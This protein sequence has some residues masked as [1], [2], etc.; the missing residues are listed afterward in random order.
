MLKIRILHAYRNSYIMKTLDCDN[1]RELVLRISM[2]PKEYIHVDV[3]C[4]KSIQLQ[5]SPSLQTKIPLVNN[6]ETLSKK[7]AVQNIHHLMLAKIIPKVL[8]TLQLSQNMRLTNSRLFI[9]NQAVLLDTMVWLLFI[10]FLVKLMCIKLKMYDNLMCM[11][12][13]ISSLYD[14][15]YRKKEVVGGEYPV[16]GKSV[17]YEVSPQT[18]I[19]YIPTLPTSMCLCWLW[20]NCTSL[21]D[22]QN[23]QDRYYTHKSRL[24]LSIENVP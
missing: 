18:E 10:L 7:R 14:I 16:K 17:L 3:K 24:N 1:I 6:L 5:V 22:M 8:K 12:S 20:F 15:S 2:I 23:L 4:L 13:N 11:I 9:L 21:F 19:Y